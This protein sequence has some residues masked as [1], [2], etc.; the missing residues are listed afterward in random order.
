MS[1]FC[2]CLTK[3]IAISVCGS[4]LSQLSSSSGVSEDFLQR[5]SIMSIAIRRLRVLSSS[6]IISSMGRSLRGL[7]APSMIGVSRFLS[8]RLA[9][10]GADRMMP[11]PVSRCFSPQ[12]TQRKAEKSRDYSGLKAAHYIRQADG[13]H[14]RISPVKRGEYRQ[15]GCDRWA[16]L[17]FDNNTLQL[18]G[19][20]GVDAPRPLYL[21]RRCGG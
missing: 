11:A 7:V 3:L 17:N 18:R 9:C 14:A 4:S 2:S 1:P 13:M 19:G 16:A 8:R 12:R 10:S 5:S 21:K 15:P 6:I 20:S